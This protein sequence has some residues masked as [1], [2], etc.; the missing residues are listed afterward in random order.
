MVEWGCVQASS[1]N[2]NWWCGVFTLPLAALA[3]AAFQFSVCVFFGFSA[4]LE[5][6]KINF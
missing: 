4:F 3:P 6:L 1:D 5:L 2:C